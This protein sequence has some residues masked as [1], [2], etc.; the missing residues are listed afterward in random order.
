MRTISR[1]ARI[2]LKKLETAH[3]VDLAVRTPKTEQIGRA[4]V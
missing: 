1:I 4:H 3:Y 2:Q